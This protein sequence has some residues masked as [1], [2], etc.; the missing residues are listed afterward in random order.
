MRQLTAGHI[1]K[2]LSPVK[3]KKKKLCISMQCV[4]WNDVTNGNKLLNIFK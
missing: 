1:S 3:R 2:I 4:Y